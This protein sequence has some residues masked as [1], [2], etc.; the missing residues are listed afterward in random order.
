MFRVFSMTSRRFS[1][2]RE[3]LSGSGVGVIPEAE[4]LTVVEQLPVEQLPLAQLPVAQLPEA[5]P[6]PQLPPHGEQP[7]ALPPYPY[8]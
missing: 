1:M 7:H 8:E 4:E 3:L 2:A 5:Q 6:Y